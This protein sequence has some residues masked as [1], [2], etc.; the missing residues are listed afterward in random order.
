MKSLSRNKENK[1]GLMAST[2]GPLAI[3]DHDF[4]VRLVHVILGF[5]FF[6]EWLRQRVGFRQN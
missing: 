2:K 4:K 6:M 5:S 1:V 3:H